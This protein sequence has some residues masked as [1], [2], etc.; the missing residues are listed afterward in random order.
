LEDIKSNSS[1]NNDIGG[2]K[3]NWVAMEGLDYVKR[4]SSGNKDIGGCKEQFE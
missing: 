1:C 4:N 2:R 3:K